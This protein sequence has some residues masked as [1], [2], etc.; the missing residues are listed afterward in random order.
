MEQ[1]SSKGQQGEQF[2]L[3]VEYLIANG[4]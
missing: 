1:R 3:T 4:Y 2:D